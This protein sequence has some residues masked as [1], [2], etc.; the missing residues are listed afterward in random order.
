VYD[1]LVDVLPP[2]DLPLGVVEAA[3]TAAAPG[4]DGGADDDDGE[5]QDAVAR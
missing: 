2:T 1:F 5:M 4:P 3:A